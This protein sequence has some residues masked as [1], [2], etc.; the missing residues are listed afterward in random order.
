VNSVARKA[1]RKDLSMP[2]TKN[3]SH[4]SAFEVAPVSSTHV[5]PKDRASSVRV[6]KLLELEHRAAEDLAEHFAAPQGEGSAEVEE[7]LRAISAYRRGVLTLH[8]RPRVW[9]AAVENALKPYTSLAIR[10]YCADHP[11]PGSTPGLEAAAAARIAEMAAAGDQSALSKL[12]CRASCH[13]GRAL[14]AYAKAL[15]AKE[16]AAATQDPS[17]SR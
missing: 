4:P 5:I 8:Y 2:A 17:S 1:T 7:N 3:P 15:R 12:E 6:P 13:H 11:A 16:R 14:R 9:P 10:L